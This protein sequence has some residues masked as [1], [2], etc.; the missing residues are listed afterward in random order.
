MAQEHA[1]NQGD[2][3]GGWGRVDVLI[4]RVVGILNKLGV[5]FK[6]SKEPYF[7]FIIVSLAYNIAPVIWQVINKYFRIELIN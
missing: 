7:L 6:K 4:K 3:A 1:W 5:E 2:K